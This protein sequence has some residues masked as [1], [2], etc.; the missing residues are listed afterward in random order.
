MPMEQVEMIIGPEIWE[1]L[2]EVISRE[3]KK[4]TV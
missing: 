1:K 2:E 4:A 3:R